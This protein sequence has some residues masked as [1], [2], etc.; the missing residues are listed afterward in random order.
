MNKYVIAYASLF[1]N[2]LQMTQVNAD[3]TLEALYAGSEY[4]GCEVRSDISDVEE[5]QD[6]CFNM[7]VLIA[8]HKII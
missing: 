2:D 7:E 4:F 6:E 3:T 8:V 1:D 5:F